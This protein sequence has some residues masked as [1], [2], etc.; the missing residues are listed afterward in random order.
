MI[1]LAGY[2]SAMVM[3]RRAGGPN[4]RP[5][6]PLRQTAPHSVGLFYFDS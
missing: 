2:F 5:Y 3:S 6:I 1:N 4:G